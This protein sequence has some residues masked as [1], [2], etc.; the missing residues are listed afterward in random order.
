MGDRLI[1]LF[2]GNSSRPEVPAGDTLHGT[3]V[4]G[5]SEALGMAWNLEKKV[6]DL[7]VIA[8]RLMTDTDTS[9]SLINKFHDIAGAIDLA[10]RRLAD[11]TVVA[12][13]DIEANLGKIDV[14]LSKTRTIADRINAAT[15]PALDS[16]SEKM[17][18]LD[19]LLAKLDTT[20]IQLDTI[21]EK[22]NK[23]KLISDR[24]LLQN[25]SGKIQDLVKLANQIRNGDTRIKLH[26]SRLKE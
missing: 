18:E 19:R 16:A 8:R 13:R 22:T 25:L 4:I 26:I 11:I 9:S 3:F 7:I 17:L 14:A 2:P 6:G 1:T 10:S 15:G 5:V 23:S 12:D 21:I 20:M 24:Q